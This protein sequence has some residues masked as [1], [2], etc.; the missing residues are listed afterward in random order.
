MLKTK[1]YYKTIRKK[2]FSSGLFCPKCGSKN[3]HKYKTD[4]DGKQW[5]YCHDCAKQ[6]RKSVFHD[7]Y[8]TLF[9]KRNSQN[10]DA[11]LNKI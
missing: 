7:L 6:K 3:I 9:Y 5:Y 11:Y 10:T 1:E 2:V 8:F 4:K